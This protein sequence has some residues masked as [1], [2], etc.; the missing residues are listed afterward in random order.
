MS[1]P[2]SQSVTI[3]AD[4]N[5]NNSLFLTANRGLRSSVASS[6]RY[7]NSWVTSHVFHHQFTLSTSCIVHLSYCL[8]IVL[9]VHLFFCQSYNLH[10]LNLYFFLVL[11]KLFTKLP[12]LQLSSRSSFPRLLCLQ[13]ALLAPLTSLV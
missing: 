8:L 3:T 13:H 5:F 7:K 6:T 11:S 10:K 9:S 12:Y 1:L 4:S 2:N